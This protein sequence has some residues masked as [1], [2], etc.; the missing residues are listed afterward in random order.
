MY[1][2]RYSM[3]MKRKA[4]YVYLIFFVFVLPSMLHAQENFKLQSENLSLQWEKKPAGYKLSNIELTFQG[5]TFTFENILGEYTLLFSEEKPSDQVDSMLYFNDISSIPESY[6]MV[7]NRWKKRLRP[8]A[9]NTA[10]EAFFFYPHQAK[11]NEG[12]IEFKQ[13]LDKAELTAVWSMDDSFKNDI[14]VEIEL[15]AKQEGYF[16]I[17]SPTLFSYK[18]E[19]I[20]WGLV[21]GHF[22]GKSINDNLLLAYGYGQ[23][24]PNKPVIARE[25]TATTL[26]PILSDKKGLSVAVIV[27]SGMGRD[28][29]DYDVSTQ[30][31]WLLGLSLM[32]RKEQLFPT[33]HHPILGEKDS[34]LRQGEKISFRFRYTLDKADWYTVYKHAVNDI[35]RFPE[36]LGKKKTNLSFTDRL[37]GMFEYLRNDSTSLWHTFH[38]KNLEIGAQEYHGPVV[39]SQKDAF[40][41]SDY[42]AMWMLAHI[43]KDSILAHNRLPYARNFK[44][45]Q[46]ADDEGFFGGAAL[47]QYYLSKSNRF[48][49]EWGDYVE[50]IA[51]TYYTMLD[52]GNVLLFEPKD[53]ELEE[54]LR[55][56]ADRLLSWQQEDGSW[57]VAYNH[58]THEVE[59][60]D[61]KDLRPTFYGLIV[62]YRILGDRKYLAAAEKGANWYIKNA[63]D[64][65]HYL[66]V[67]GDFRFVPDFATGQSVQALLDLYDLT[68]KET[69][70]TAALIAARQYTTSIFTHPIPSNKEKVIKNKVV[71]DWE[72]SQVGLS[73]EHG[74]AL[75]SAAKVHGPILLAS[76]AGMFVRLFEMT[77]DSLFID[78]ARAG[79]WGRDAFVNKENSVA[80][81]YWYS[82][83]QGPGRFPHHAWWQVGWITDYLLSEIELR[84]GGKITFPRGFVTPK[85]GPHQSYGFKKGSVFGEQADLLLRPDVVNLDNPQIDYFMATSKNKLFILLLNNSQQQEKGSLMVNYGNVLGKSI[86]LRRVY[87][88]TFNG[89]GT[90]VKDLHHWDISIPA[91]G[92]N[93]L[94]IEYK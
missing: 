34:Y 6:I 82:F 12:S 85:V 76:H 10:G 78:M 91:Y 16:S 17:Q 35:Y 72:I 37:L 20:S 56:G 55:R 23:G 19:D 60:K 65:G 29:W 52:I 36:V 89:P 9:M 61:L 33:I 73:F 41:N 42:G 64:E 53:K 62:A 71:K 32:N 2:S 63:I 26:S 66:G 30:N 31:D 43:T 40:K 81:Y 3:R 11:Y 86:N 25:R 54:L 69:Y 8:V 68:K 5:Q 75:G 90:I 92:L 7:Y 94:E 18:E 27:Q 24:I 44:I 15:T 79:V 45:A 48:T 50:P 58:E 46:Q 74:G 22:Q 21:P 28:Y 51:L 77:G 39:G 14:L 4:K 47:G 57:V 13:Q 88:H 59:F 83:D 1:N 49:E 93:V 80:S 38:F 70:K 67:C 84:S 87:L